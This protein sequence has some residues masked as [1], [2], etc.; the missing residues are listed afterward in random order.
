M[1]SC[2]RGASKETFK[3]KK[4]LILNA[5]VLLSIR[6][7]KQ[8]INRIFQ[9]AFLFKSSHCKLNILFNNLKISMLI[10]NT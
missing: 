2:H 8:K 7:T 4:S 5:A 10:L 9:Y 6:F 1:D 3:F